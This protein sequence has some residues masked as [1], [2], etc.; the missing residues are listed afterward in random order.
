MAATQEAKGQD[1]DVNDATDEC[2]QQIDDKAQTSFKL[3]NEDSFPR[4]GFGTS[5]SRGISAYWC[6][7]QDEIWNNDEDANLMM[8]S[9]A[10]KIVR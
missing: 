10:P 7:S 8:N 6:G 4:L 2:K 3:S 9:T 1:N 5:W